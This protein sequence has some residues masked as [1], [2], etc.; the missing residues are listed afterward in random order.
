[1]RSRTREA[2]FRLLPA[3]LAA[4][5]ALGCS[6]LVYVPSKNLLGAPEDPPGDVWFAGADG[7]EL[8]GWWFEARTPR[9][10]TVVQFHGNAGNITS[11]YA[12]LEW[13]TAQGYDFFT[14]DYRGYGRSGGSPTLAGVH[15]DALAAFAYASRRS[16]ANPAADLVLY[17]QSLGG[18]VVLRMLDDVA[19]QRQIRAVIVEGT[20]HSYQDAAAAV[21]WREPL[22]FLFTGLAYSL[23]SDDYA[24][25][26][27][28]GR[29]AP[30]P[31]LV[32]HDVHDPVVPFGFGKAVYQLARAPKEFWPVDSGGHVTA[33]RDPA[34]RRAL[35]AWLDEKGRAPASTK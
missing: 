10:G 3:S 25:S 19:D 26:A 11:H 9:R 12:S 31:L 20:F 32:V 15:G 2:A 22:S 16:A 24:P 14:F 17:G 6:S 34:F 13:V 29:V 4:S 18:A 23:V 28:I 30:I 27:S 33:Q 21:L 5:L 35:V 7:T 8:H 1:M